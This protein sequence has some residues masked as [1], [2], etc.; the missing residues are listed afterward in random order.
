MISSRS[1]EFYGDLKWLNPTCVW[2]DCVSEL[3]T[4]HISIGIWGLWCSQSKT[5]PSSVRI[6]SH[7][8]NKCTWICFTV[9]YE[10][11]TSQGQCHGVLVDWIAIFAVIQQCNSKVVLWQI[12]PFVTP[13][14]RRTPWKTQRFNSIAFVMTPSLT[15]AVLQFK[16]VSP[17]QD[18]SYCPKYPW[19]CVHYA[20][21]L[22]QCCTSNLAQSHEVFLCVGLCRWPNWI[23]YVALRLRTR[24]GNSTLRNLW[25]SA[26]FT[27]NWRV[28]HYWIIDSLDFS[29][30]HKCY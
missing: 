14:L 13:N 30:Y 11:G 8:W 28:Q 22:T 5:K 18:T 19:Q 29:R 12:S 23:S 21:Q 15:L 7:D 10:G 24:T 16:H 9:I 2:H 3:M 1:K 27:W 25:D 20:E 26:H 6:C 17:K 4:P